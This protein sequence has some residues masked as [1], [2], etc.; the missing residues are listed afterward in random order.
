M[1]AYGLFAAP[2]D[3]PSRELHALV[4]AALDEDG[5]QRD[6]RLPRSPGGAVPQEVT[7]APRRVVHPRVVVV[8]GAPLEAEAFHHL[9]EEPRVRRRPGEA[10]RLLLV[11]V[12]RERAPDGVDGRRDPERPRQ[13]HGKVADVHEVLVT[14]VLE[15]L[16]TREARPR[17]RGIRPVVL[18][19]HDRQQPFAERGHPPIVA[20][21][22][23]KSCGRRFD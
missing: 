12:L 18:P 7:V 14:E 11:E 20:H 2:A 23:Q 15:E 22:G 19:I 3:V 5:E 9:Q 13:E 8:E 21:L 1:L 10:P 6:A 4:H 17:E 16:F